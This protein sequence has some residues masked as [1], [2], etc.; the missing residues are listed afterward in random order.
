VFIKLLSVASFEAQKSRRKVTK[1]KHKYVH[2]FALNVG[3]TVKKRS[4]KQVRKNLI[5]KGSVSSYSFPY[6]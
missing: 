6:T 3:F 5:N 2:N 4:K 1:I